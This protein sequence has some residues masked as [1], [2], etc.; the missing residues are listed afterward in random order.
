M[1]TTKTSSDP[2]PALVGL[3]S[4]VGDRLSWL[5]FARRRVAALDSTTV[6][7]ASAVFE[8][9]PEGGPPQARYLNACLALSTRLAPHELLDSLLAIEAAAGRVRSVRN[10]P[11]TLDLDVLLFGALA[12]ADSRLT[13]PHPRF[14]SRA[15]ALVPAAEIA[16]AWPVPPSDVTVSELAA[17]AGAAGLAR[18]YD[19]GEW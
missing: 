12:F 13:V 7:A 5:K 10:A 15:F 9:E 18:A 11:R 14:A 4:N 2:T 8:T 16:A 17:R 1:T 3:G 6:T 19:E